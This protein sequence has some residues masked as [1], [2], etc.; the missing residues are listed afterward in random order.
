MKSDAKPKDTATKPTVIKLPKTAG[1]TL[2]E[3]K[4]LSAKDRSTL[5][6]SQQRQLDEAHEQ[7]QKM[8][9]TL[10][11]R[12]YLLKGLLKGSALR[13]VNLY[14]SCLYFY[15]YFLKIVFSAERNSVPRLKYITKKKPDTKPGSFYG[16]GTGTL[17]LDLVLGKD[18]L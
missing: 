18:A 2:R 4:E 14:N 10:S 1:L 7:L 9:A 15:T 17:T 8:A 5:T 13:S 11:S 12:Y 6:S 16:A 3:Y